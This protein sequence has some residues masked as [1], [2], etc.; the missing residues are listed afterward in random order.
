MNSDVCIEITGGEGK[1]LRT[2]VLISHER[3]MD[4]YTKAP[5]C[6]DTLLETDVLVLEDQVPAALG[7]AQ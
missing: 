3:S 7:P 1:K 5:T 6:L 2:P 4:E